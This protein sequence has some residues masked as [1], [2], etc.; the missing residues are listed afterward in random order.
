MHTNEIYGYIISK[1]QN[2]HAPACIAM[3]LICLGHRISCREV[4]HVVRAYVDLST[5]NKGLGRR[6]R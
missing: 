4:M 1:W 2:G 3:Y 5:E 6:V